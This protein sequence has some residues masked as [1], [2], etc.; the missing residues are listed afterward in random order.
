MRQCREYVNH[1][2]RLFARYQKCE[3]VNEID[4][5]NWCAVENVLDDLKKEDKN[6]IIKIYEKYDTIPDNVYEVSKELNL[7]Q[8]IIWTLLNKV[9]KKIAK[10][11]GLI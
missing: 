3:L 9:C 2:L 5:E 6:V 11:R 1:M 4:V 10:E 7:H 8:D